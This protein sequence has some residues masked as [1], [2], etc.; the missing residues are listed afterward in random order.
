MCPS[1][2]GPPGISW[3]PGK[4]HSI[5]IAIVVTS[6]GKRRWILLLLC[7]W[8]KHLLLLD[9][10]FSEMEELHRVISREL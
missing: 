10:S 8:I 9:L 7:Y 5:K 6:A 4:L 1:V 2:I 3:L